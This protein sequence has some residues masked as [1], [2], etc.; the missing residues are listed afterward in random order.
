LG[1]GLKY[2]LTFVSVINR[3]VA[4]PPKKHHVIQCSFS[5]ILIKRSSLAGYC[6][7]KANEFVAKLEF[8]GWTCA[9]TI[10]DKS[11]E[12]ESM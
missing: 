8:W 5:I 4:D 3:P 12:A 6:E 2:I 9:E 11:S 7:Q 10:A 1:L